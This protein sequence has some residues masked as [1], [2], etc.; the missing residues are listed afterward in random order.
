MWPVVYHCYPERPES[1]LQL[2][3][4][5][6]HFQF[7]SQVWTHDL[8]HVS[9]VLCELSQ[10]ASS[11]TCK[12]CP[13]FSIELWTALAVLFLAIT[14]KFNCWSTFYSVLYVYWIIQCRG[15]FVAVTLSRVVAPMT[16]VMGTGLTENS[17]VNHLLLYQA[18]QLHSLTS[19]NFAIIT[20]D[21][22]L[23]YIFFLFAV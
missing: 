3:S 12:C 17:A 9:P 7:V 15:T 10:Q 18:H 6:K 11:Y 16:G 2:S 5:R 20:K 1:S 21:M 8:P 14:S 13:G 19:I 22:F 23:H 4:E